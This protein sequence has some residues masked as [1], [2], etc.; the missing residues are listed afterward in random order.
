MAIRAPDGANNN[1]TRRDSNERKQRDTIPMKEIKGARYIVIFC[2]WRPISAAV[3][4]GDYSRGGDK[5]QVG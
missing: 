2:T 3:Q 1:A 4:E 5:A